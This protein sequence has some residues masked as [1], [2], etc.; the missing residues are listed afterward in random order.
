MSLLP[1]T[2]LGHFEIVSPL[3]AGGMGEVYRARDTRPALAREVAVKV[4]SGATA[5]D[6]SRRRFE[7]EARATGALNH[8]NILAIYDVGMHDGLLYLVEELVEGSTLRAQL[9][10]GSIQVRKAIEYGRSIAQGLAAAHAKGIIHRDLK[11]ENVMVT[12]DGRVKILDFGLAK[13]HEPSPT[14]NDSTQTHQ[15][16]PGTILGTVAYMSPEQLRAQAVD[17]RGDLFSLGVLLYEMLSGARPF[18]GDTSV[19]TQAAILNAEPPEFAADRAIPPAVD[20]VVRRCLEKRPE[21]RF[22]SASDLAFALDALSSAALS[23]SAL[24]TTAMSPMG[25]DPQR[26]GFR[27]WQLAT[28]VV[29]GL[30]VGAI[31]AMVKARPTATQS[32]ARQTRLSVVPPT[33][34]TVG[35]GPSG[36]SPARILSLSPDGTRL[37]FV[38]APKDGP[39][40]IYIRSLDSE[41]LQS[42]P[43]TEEAQYP[44]WSPDGNSLAFYVTGFLRRVELTGGSPRTLCPAPANVAGGTWSGNTIL[45]SLNSPN[46]PIMRVPAEGGTAEPV[47]E[48]DSKAG[49]SKHF[50]P[51]FLPDGDHFLYLGVGRTSNGT[52]TATGLYVGSLSSKSRKALQPVGS[53][54]QYAQGHLVFMDGTSVAAQPFDPVRLELAGKP[55]VIATNVRIGGPALVRGAFSVAR[56]GT[57][58]FLHG[59]SETT[60]TLTWFDRTGAVL[61]TLGDPANYTDI[62]LSPDGRRVAISLQDSQSGNTDIWLYDIDNAGA[63]TRFTFERNEDR[64]PVWSPDGSQLAFG[65]ERVVPRAVFIKPTSGVG[66]ERPLVS[67]ANANVAP[68]A[69][70]PDGKSLLLYGFGDILRWTV[71]S[72]QPPTGLVVGPSDDAYPKISANGRWVAYRS[73]ETNR[74]EIFVVPLD[75]G[76]GRSQVSTMGGSFP[77]WRQDNSELYF[78]AANGDLYAVPI[79]A[80]SAGFEFGAPRRLFQP[81]ART[82]YRFPYDVTDDGQRFLVSRSPEQVAAAPITVVSNWVP[83]LPH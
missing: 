56:N 4:L 55:T 79:N 66:D 34:V 30:A 18:V 16:G 65:S 9:S 6:E 54:A 71:G 61:G 51:F 8:P 43:G 14:S 13:L 23:S 68:G 53:N 80:Q 42:L 28:A 40:R 21:H 64:S 38:G 69:W 29:L 11:P 46:A 44:F 67:V 37:A 73:L 58:A 25:A 60:T 39:A 3:G 20:R 75:G 48:L 12:D 81:R 83:A 1:G 45:F 63:K 15:T 77:R 22:Q 19:D 70:T 2:R 27:G 50:A 17:H 76:G 36:V 47:T 78:I 24:P 31:G 41:E 49:E 32:D 10:K 74:S 72:S 26:R 33:D 7:Q 35:G 52:D 62:E 82:G 5:G 57:I 59:V